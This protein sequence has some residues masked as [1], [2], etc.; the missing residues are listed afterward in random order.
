MNL[1]KY[2]PSDFGL[3]NSWVTTAELLFQFAG[4]AWTY[5][6]DEKQ[7]QK[8]QATFP[9]RQFYMGIDDE[10]NAFAFGEIIVGDINSPRL[11][12]LLIGDSAS[13]GKGLGHSFVNLLIDECRQRIETDVI[14]L[15]V[16]PDNSSA[17]RCYEKAGF[18]F[19][20]DKSVTFKYDD[21]DQI[22]LLMEYRVLD[23]VK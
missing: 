21:V 5:P 22:A 6:L 8:Y 13:R 9:D 14:Y 2:L 4:T 17:I 12:R 15:Y 20:P 7:V 3:L 23:K 18:T 16:F 1:R 19:V 10:N 11:G